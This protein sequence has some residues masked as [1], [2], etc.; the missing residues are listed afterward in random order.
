MTRSKYL[1]LVSLL[2]L[3]GCVVGP[4][5]EKPQ[6]DVPPAW[7]PEPPWR[8]AAPDDAALKGAWWKIFKDAELNTLE[9]AALEHNPSLD[10]AKARL[11]QAQDVVRVTSAGLFPQLGLASGAQRLKISKD[12]PA[13]SFVVPNVSTVQND[14]TLGFSVQY[15]AD[16]FGSIKRQIESASASAQQSQADLE[17]A[18]LVLSAELAADYFNLRELDLEIDVI[19]RSIASENRALEFVRS[20]H[21]LGDASGLDLAQQEAQVKTTITQIDLLRNRRAQYEHALATLMG[22]P[23]PGFEIAPAQVELEVPAI[24][25]AVPS[26]VI[27]RRPDVASQERAMA[28]A[29]AQIG[30]ARAAFFPSVP[31]SA[32]LGLE[33]NTAST[34]L[35][36]SSLF[37][38]FGVSAVQTIFDAGQRQANLDYAKAG[39]TAVVAGYRGTVLSAMQEVEDGLSGM[40]TLGSASEEADAAVTSAQRVLD[41]ANDRYSGGVATYLDVVTA[42][43][44]LLAN[45]RQAVQIRGQEMVT[46]VYLIKALGGG[47]SA[48]P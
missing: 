16:L 14:F 39:Y 43:Q 27:Q 11:R 48:S 2:V 38:S 18:G 21:D 25:V 31:L 34:L 17:N 29:N 28:A 13:A 36:A 26:D 37:W 7:K 10:V 47:W 6:I 8:Q 9:Q 5:Y 41:L 46:A 20:R 35:S 15:E 23:A 1:S 22:T 30:V 33:S 19:R 40:S 12:R 3:A 32:N 45:Q 42:Q 44:A 24:P 4:N